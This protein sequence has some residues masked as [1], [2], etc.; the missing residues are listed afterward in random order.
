[1]VFTDDDSYY[2][3]D[4]DN[5]FF[6]IIEQGQQN[7]TLGREGGEARDEIDSIEF[8]ATSFTCYLN[9]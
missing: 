5:P 1:M 6:Q 2:K 4:Y 9:S 7:E 8:A 3:T